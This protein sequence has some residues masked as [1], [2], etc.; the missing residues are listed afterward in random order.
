MVAM[1]KSAM[2]HLVRFHFDFSSF[3]TYIEQFCFLD[4]LLHK[5]DKKQFLTFKLFEITFIIILKHLRYCAYFDQIPIVVVSPHIRHTS[6]QE[7]DGGQLIFS[8]VSEASLLKA[9]ILTNIV[10]NRARPE[11]EEKER[12]TASGRTFRIQGG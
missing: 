11:N 6:I 9:Q 7:C 3:I 4:I 12:K 5:G 2:L 8:K 1:E 10:L